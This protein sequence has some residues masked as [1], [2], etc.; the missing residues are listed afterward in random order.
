MDCE[1]PA[2]SPMD[3]HVVVDNMLQGLGRQLRACGIDVK[4]LENHEDH[5][6]AAEV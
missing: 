3:L 4:V 6:V 1:R 2:I 5:E